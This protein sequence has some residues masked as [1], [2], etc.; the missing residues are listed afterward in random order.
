MVVSGEVMNVKGSGTG[1]R[2]SAVKSGGRGA[3]AGG[4]VAS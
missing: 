4:G 1:N 2:G 3:C